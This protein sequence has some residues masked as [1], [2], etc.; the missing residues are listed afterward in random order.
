M[1]G[2]L[3]AEALAGAERRDHLLEA[4]IEHLDDVVPQ[5]E[6]VGERPQPEGVLGQG[7]VGV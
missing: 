4:V 1:L 3:G 6:I 5:P 2:P 7:G